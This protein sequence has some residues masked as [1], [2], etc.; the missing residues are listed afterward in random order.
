[1]EYVIV[2]VLCLIVGFFVGAKVGSSM[3]YIDILLV[4]DE[5]EQLRYETE[6]AKVT[7]LRLVS[8]MEQQIADGY[9][10]RGR[11]ERN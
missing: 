7:A 4:L 9:E 8:D 10:R 11:A 6:S 1:M 5:N 2:G 3:K